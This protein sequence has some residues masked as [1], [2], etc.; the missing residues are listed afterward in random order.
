MINY[1]NNNFY[2]F[3]RNSIINSSGRD[4]QPSPQ[5]QSIGLRFKPCPS[6]WAFESLMVAIFLCLPLGLIAMYYS[7]KVEN[8][9]HTGRYD[10]AAAASAKA[11]SFAIWGA[12]IGAVAWIV[13]GWLCLTG[14]LHSHLV[15]ITI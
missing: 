10:E 15:T 9:Y 11:R 6:S 3:R 1:D 12:R 8:R 4:A 7:S 14:S 13:V 5:S 2:D